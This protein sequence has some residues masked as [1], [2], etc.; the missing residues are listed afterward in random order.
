MEGLVN[1]KKCHMHTIV[2]ESHSMYVT[3]SKFQ[4][5][6]HFHYLFVFNIFK[7]SIPHLIYKYNQHFIT[8]NNLKIISQIFYECLQ[9]L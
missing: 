1:V 4:M 9:K 3:N 2:L 7:L 6:F 8:T 5:I